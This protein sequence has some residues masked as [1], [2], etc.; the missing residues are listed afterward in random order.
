MKTNINGKEGVVILERTEENKIRI[1]LYIK[2]VP[3]YILG[4]DYPWI[5]Q[6]LESGNAQRM[7]VDE[8]Q[9]TGQIIGSFIGETRDD[10][11]NK[12]LALEYIVQTCSDLSD[13]GSLSPAAITTYKRMVES[14]DWA[15]AKLMGLHINISSNGDAF[16]EIEGVDVD[17][18]VQDDVREVHGWSV[19]LSP[20]VFP[21]LPDAVKEVV[22]AKTLTPMQ[23]LMHDLDLI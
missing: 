4:N 3:T 17:Y 18:V 7:G 11:I 22:F 15:F 10:R 23:R 14:S 9:L 5:R 12:M 8:H 13:I 20:K 2:G 16:T 21:R 6:Q 1:S 19:G